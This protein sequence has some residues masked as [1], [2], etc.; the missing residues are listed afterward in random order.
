MC[1]RPSRAL[2][3]A[4][5]RATLPLVINDNRE[6]FTR[7]VVA[8]RSGKSHLKSCPKQTIPLFVPPPSREH[9]TMVGDAMGH[10][11]TK[12][13]MPKTMQRN[14][15]L[16]FPRQLAPWSSNFVNAPP[17]NE[18]HT[19]DYVSAHPAKPASTRHGTKEIG[20]YN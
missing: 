16:H 7:D 13:Y 10:K 4:N 17:K 9:K 2:I 14:Y 19:I 8:D 11:P 5:Q 6:D 15:I 18:D 20:G 12:H 1:C 3:K